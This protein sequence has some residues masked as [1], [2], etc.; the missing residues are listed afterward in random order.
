MQDC[1]RSL[2]KIGWFL[3][4]YGDTGL[5]RLLVMTDSEISPTTD[6][7]ISVR[8]A[9][10]GVGQDCWGHYYLLD[11]SK[12]EE[13][14]FLATNLKKGDTF[15]LD[16][17][18][19]HHKTNAHIAF[20][21]RRIFDQKYY[22]LGADHDGN[23]NGWVGDLWADMWPAWMKR[24]QLPEA[25]AVYEAMKHLTS[26]FGLAECLGSYDGAGYPDF[27][28]DWQ[29]PDDW[30]YGTIFRFGPGITNRLHIPLEEQRMPTAEEIADERCGFE[31]EQACWTLDVSHSDGARG[32]G[33]FR[34]AGR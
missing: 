31:G 19:R 13:H 10:D 12:I 25:I 3:C 20:H 32:R 5:V 11:F 30:K 34:R 29:A 33:V 4:T 21:V 1:E 16:V 26:D 7:L 28:A 27:D 15:T 14:R 6:G 2:Q 17:G 24:E 22:H 8:K 23:V 18:F 9:S